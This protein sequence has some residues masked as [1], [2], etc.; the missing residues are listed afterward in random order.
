MTD[1]KSLTIPS[2][3]RGEE[4]YPQFKEDFLNRL[5]ILNLAR[6]L[7]LSGKLKIP[8]KIDEDGDGKFTDAELHLWREYRK[9][10]GLTQEAIKYNIPEM[11][12]GLIA[13]SKN[14]AEMWKKLTNHYEGSGYIRKLISIQDYVRMRY[15]SYDTIQ[16][17]NNAFNEA[18]IRLNQLKIAPPTE[19]HSIMYISAL[20][21]AWP[22]WATN[23]RIRARDLETA[24]TLE[25]LQNDII[26][27]NRSRGRSSIDAG[28]ALAAHNRKALGR[29]GKPGDGPGREPTWCD[30]CKKWGW[31]VKSACW[32]AN[33]KL[34]A[35]H[36]QKKGKDTKSDG[37]SAKTATSQEDNN[38]SSSDESIHLSALNT[39]KVTKKTGYMAR[40]RK[41]NSGWKADTG[42]SDDYACDPGWFNPGTLVTTGEM[43]SI[44]TGN[45]DVVAS[46][47]GKVTL[48]CVL[49][50][51]KVQVLHLEKV[52]YLPECPHCL[53]AGERFYRQKGWFKHGKMYIANGKEI[54]QFDD[55]MFIILDKA[56]TALT[57]SIHSETALPAALQK[58]KPTFELM[59][60]RFGHI[61]HDSL[62]R[63]MA[64]VTG[65]N[66]FTL[67]E[68]DHVGTKLCEPCEL[69]KPIRRTRKTTDRRSNDIFGRVH[70]DVFK[71]LP[72]GPKGEGVAILFTDDASRARWIVNGRTK[73]DAQKAIEWFVK[74]VKTQYNLTVKAWRLDGG[75]EYGGD[76]MNDMCVSL[77]STLE[78][79]TPY[80]PEQDGISERGG[81]IIIERTRTVMIDSNIPKYL[82]TYIIHAVV[83]IVNR[84]MSRAV[85][86][87]ITPYEALMNQVDKNKDNR[88]DISHIFVLG[89]RTW[90]QI[91]K[92]R[93]I[94][95]QK[96]A[97]RAE[98]GI[99]VGFEGNHI[100]QVWVKTR[101]KGHQLVRTSNISVDEGEFSEAPS[102]GMINVEIAN[103]EVIKNDPPQQRAIE[104]HSIPNDKE[105]VFE[106]SSSAS[107]TENI[108]KHLTNLEE[109]IT[110]AE[111]QDEF[112]EDFRDPNNNEGN[113]DHIP[114]PVTKARR[115][116]PPGSKN[117]SKSTPPGTV[118]DRVTRAQAKV[119][120]LIAQQEYYKIEEYTSTL[121]NAFKTSIDLDNGDPNTLQ[122]ALSGANAE[123]WREAVERE[124]KSLAENDTFTLTKKSK[125]QPQHK[126]LGG[127]L[128]FKT[129]RGKNGEI[130]KFKVRWVVKGYAQRK[131][132]DY[133]ETY[134]GVC[135]SVTWKVCFARAAV[136]DWEVEQMDAI[137]AFLN[138]ESDGEIYVEIP[139]QFLEILNIKKANRN[140]WVCRLLKSLYGLKQAPRLWQEKLIGELGKMGYFAIKADSSAYRNPKTEITIL[141]YVDD[142][143]IIGPAG[144]DLNSVKSGLCNAFK[145]EDLGPASYF[146]G[147]RI[148][149]DRSARTIKLCQDA[150]IKKIIE[151]FG[152]ADCTTVKTPMDPGQKEFMVPFEGQAS[153]ADIQ[154]YQRMV[155][156]EM[157]AAVQTR[158]DIAY[159]LTV[160]SRFLKNPSPAHMI[161]AKRVL[162]YLKGSIYTC[163]EYGPRNDVTIH[164]YADSDYAGDLEKRRSTSGYCFFLGG[165]IISWRT[166]RQTVVALSSTE[167]EY[168]GL[169]Y[170]MREA[171]WLRKLLT[172]LQYTSQDAKSILIRGD[173]AGALALAKN[174]EFHQRTK[175]I[176]VQWHFVQ[177]QVKK[178]KVKVEFIGTSDMAADG[179]TKGL[180]R[181]L[182]QRFMGLIRLSKLDC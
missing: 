168:Y 139:P 110:N 98:E 24:P 95:A 23:Q 182:H 171:I 176:E 79:T 137:T 94:A 92:E 128:V 134:A 146:L 38:D 131:G 81:R 28:T 84:T 121:R 52:Y 4:N 100:Y 91:P 177:D 6:Y 37:K 8:K 17:F 148:V 123:M 172:E 163:I 108:E 25:T 124:Y 80:T 48:N 73:K 27:E 63:T 62:K 53:F 41:T 5:E 34:K 166:I 29:H 151:K 133:E 155:G 71:M 33:P 9:G 117:R 12:K 162:R 144:N 22:Q 126:V 40:I 180:T 45:G 66:K 77:G 165:G 55:D 56:S 154:L 89:S 167:S 178:G 120:A 106:Q 32:I 109:E 26:D 20:D 181:V 96:L 107:H 10:D 116:R 75:K 169:A 158:P 43:P 78:L 70:V 141:V 147:I 97:P 50:N 7:N 175:H 67:P 82:W 16:D 150:Y 101:P 142:F 14:A 118:S 44:S 156:S 115:G 143:L 161:A 105:T 179:F 51:G 149:R 114:E 85:T 127:R 153:A 102:L 103:G 87:N 104:S 11:A 65:F 93:R 60:R 36:N 58:G 46:G 119:V 69:A 132:I 18:I 130:V 159:T 15:E 129:K 1:Y 125:L 157:H 35:E 49:S 145:M 68:E 112:T 2:K 173:N 3:L 174:P 152:M 136:N 57:T 61:S 160:L 140:E 13:G 113:P 21:T 88:P 99:L 30:G 164:G 90:V 170:S 19:W 59:H 122:E 111:A 31:H 39:K 74:M 54:G 64:V 42:A 135:K 86:G 72:L 138:G 83:H 76:K 47:Y